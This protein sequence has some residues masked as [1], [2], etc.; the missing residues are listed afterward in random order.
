[1][2][3]SWW[4]A[5]EVGTNDRAKAEIKALF[6]KIH[7][8]FQTAKPERLI[9]RIIGI[10]SN[11]DD[12]VLD[13]FAGSGTT[14]A[15]A[16]KMDRRWVT[17]DW[18]RENLESYAL[19]R[20]KKVVGGEDPGGVTQ[21][22]GWEGGGGFRV[23]DIAPSMFAEDDGLVVL[24][25][26]AVAG[27]LGEA[28]A[29]QLDYDHEPRPPFVGRKGRTRLAVIDGLVN[30]DVAHLLVRSLGEKERLVICGTAVDPEARGVLRELRPGSTVRKIPASILAEYLTGQR[31][32]PRR[33]RKDEAATAVPTHADGQTKKQPKKQAKKPTTSAAKAT[34]MKPTAKKRPRART[35]A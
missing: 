16:H 21:V 5:T 13:C 7:D 24:A 34:T 8:P 12:I 18:S 32:K 2:P 1:V 15:V 35:K 19:P 3:T 10:A 14:A 11:P 27:E 26:W 29:A 9:A 31:W 17:V 4:P 30:A 6:P 25:D 23:L 20:L 22:T 28:T 33:A